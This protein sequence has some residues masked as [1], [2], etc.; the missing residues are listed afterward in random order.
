MKIGQL[1]LTISQGK[2]NET[3][4]FNDIYEKSKNQGIIHDFAAHCAINNE[5]MAKG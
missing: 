2:H 3:Y 4:S 5:R 1:Q